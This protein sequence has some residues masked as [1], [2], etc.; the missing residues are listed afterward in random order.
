MNAEEMRS[1]QLSSTRVFYQ[2]FP[3]D[4]LHKHLVLALQNVNPYILSVVV[5]ESEKI[6]TST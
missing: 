1:L 2:S 3:L 6:E 4:K 5:D